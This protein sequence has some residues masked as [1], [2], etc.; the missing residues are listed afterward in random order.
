MQTS[1]S[2]IF[3]IL[4]LLA[5]NFTIILSDALYNGG[6]RFRLLASIKILFIA[7]IASITSYQAM[8]SVTPTV[9][10]LIIANIWALQGSFFVHYQVPTI[11][12]TRAHQIVLDMLTI[13]YST[14]YK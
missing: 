12:K 10:R 8:L 14:I 13:Q 4:K 11:K 6:D 7:G 1:H 2:Y 3:Y 5:T 9:F